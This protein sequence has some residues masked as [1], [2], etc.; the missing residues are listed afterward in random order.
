MSTEAKYET[1]WLSQKTD[2]TSN[3]IKTKSWDKAAQFRCG[4]LLQGFPCL[5]WY[6]SRIKF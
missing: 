6:Y 2:M 4:C 3:D 1:F 5:E